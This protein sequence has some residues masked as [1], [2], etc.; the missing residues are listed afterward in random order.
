MAVPLSNKT[1]LRGITE[2]NLLTMTVAADGCAVNDLNHDRAF[3]LALTWLALARDIDSLSFRGLSRPAGNCKENRN[4]NGLLICVKL[5]SAG[6]ID[7]FCVERTLR[8]RTQG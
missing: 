8:E 4:L 3:V 6:W 2:W 1:P 7:R 5:A